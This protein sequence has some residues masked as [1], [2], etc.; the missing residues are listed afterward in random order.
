MPRDIY[1]EAQP[2]S[3]T[4]ITTFADFSTW[5]KFMTDMGLD[6]TTY[7]LDETTFNFLKWFGG[8]MYLKYSNI[9]KNRLNCY[10]EWKN[11]I[12]YITKIQPLYDKD[13]M[14]LL[15]QINTNKAYA[16]SGDDSDSMNGTDPKPNT[17]SYLFSTAVSEKN[18]TFMGAILALRS[19]YFN[20]WTAEQFLVKNF[21]M[22]VMARVQPRSNY[23]D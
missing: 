18:P 23:A 1:W 17:T 16:P 6:P 14:D 5:Q 21:F 12:D 3:A 9:N 19:Q 8:N 4:F 11:T 7:K 20:G 13:V 22:K 2:T 10:W 15:Q